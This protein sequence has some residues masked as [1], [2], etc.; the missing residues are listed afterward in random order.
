MPKKGWLGQFTDLGG[1]G[2]GGLDKKDRVV[3]LRGREGEG[4]QGGRGGP[5]YTITNPML[6]TVF[7]LC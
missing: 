4:G 2:G 7:Y 3:I 5:G 6:I 1:E